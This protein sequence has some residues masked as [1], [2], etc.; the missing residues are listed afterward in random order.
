LA[1]FRQHDSGR[2]ADGKLT[3]GMGYVY[4]RSR[5]RN[6]VFAQMKLRYLILASVWILLGSMC[7]ACTSAQTLSHCFALT[8]FKDGESIPGPNIVVFHDKTDRSSSSI[9]EGKFCIPDSMISKTALDLSFEL[10]NEIFYFSRI[11]AG[12]F[13]S[14]W[15]I[16]F[17]DKDTALAARLPKG[18]KL[19]RA[20]SV[21]FHQGEPDIGV[22]YSACRL[23]IRKVQK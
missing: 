16:S 10:G 8:I 5:D 7:G 20:C 6:T 23:P 21:I 17:G 12:R 9:R 14:S 3:I 11:P 15:D 1:F 4:A 18:A 22:I 13:Q 19:N 2:L